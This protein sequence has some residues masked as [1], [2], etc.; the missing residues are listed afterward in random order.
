MVLRDQMHLESLPQARHHSE[1]FFQRKFHTVF[2]PP[3]ASK[4]WVVYRR[5]GTISAFTVEA[6]KARKRFIKVKPPFVDCEMSVP[7]SHDSAAQPT[8]LSPQ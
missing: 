2:T 4:A 7:N 8:P 3:N 1:F 6:F 5:T